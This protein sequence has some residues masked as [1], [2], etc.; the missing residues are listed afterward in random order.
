MQIKILIAMLS[1]FA[2]GLFLV[3]CDQKGQII[4]QEAKSFAQGQVDFEIPLQASRKNHKVYL[5]FDYRYVDSNEYSVEV[6]LTRPN[7]ETTFQVLQEKKKDVATKRPGSTNFSR[8][9]KQGRD[10]HRVFT[11]VPQET[12]TYLIEAYQDMSVVGAS[13]GRVELEVRK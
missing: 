8:N 5:N 9:R 2:M 3:S 4:H 10:E 6:R 7:Q 11:F 13:L 1:F 12:G